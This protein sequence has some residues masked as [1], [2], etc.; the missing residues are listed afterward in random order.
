[1]GKSRLLVIFGLFILLI[2]LA[3]A[4]DFDNDLTVRIQVVN[5][6]SHIQ[7]NQQFIFDFNISYGSPLPIAGEA[8]P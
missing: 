6:S 5:D 3:Y 2:N 4:A 1:M 7:G 8:M